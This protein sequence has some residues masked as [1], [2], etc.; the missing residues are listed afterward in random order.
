MKKTFA[1]FFASLGLLALL[2]GC[3]S[4]PK[5][6]GL[7]VEL[8]KLE[9][10]ADG[11][12]IATLRYTNPNVVAYNVASSTHKLTLNG[13]SVGTITAEGAVGIPQQFTLTH[14]G[15]LKLANGATLPAG[16]AAYSMSSALILRLYGDATDKATFTNSGT[17]EIVTR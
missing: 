17:V 1:L 10:A 6:R 2:A 5:I 9:Q 11:T 12:V 16:S 8:A 15:R 7:T 13:R 4:S 14:T 3:A